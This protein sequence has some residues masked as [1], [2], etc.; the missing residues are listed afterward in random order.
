MNKLDNCCFVYC[1]T[2]RRFVDEAI[3]S[4]LSV[5]AVMPNV[6]RVLFT[7]DDESTRL[8]G[9]G[10]FDRVDV[11][12]DPDYGFRDKIRPLADLEFD[13]IVFLDSD[14]FMM[15]SISEVFELLD[16]FELAFCY[17]PIRY[18]PDYALEGVSDAFTEPNT[19]VLAF[20]RTEAVV[21]LLRKWDK[22]YIEQMGS[23]CPPDHDQ[24]SFREVVYKSDVKF[25]IL[26]CEYNLRT[27]FPYFKGRGILTKILHSRG[28]DLEQALEALDG[29]VE[30]HVDP[31]ELLGVRRR[32]YRILMDISY[33][34]KRVLRNAK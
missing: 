28:R 11:I 12:L 32:F 17:S 24:P 6:P 2:G 34:I 5:K 20:R 15:N 16:V 7:N 29:N 3:Q 9:T 8:A 27:V 23:C 10:V 4:A 18:C 25:C 1:A 13:K 19:G 26:P 21:E 14:T 31:K 22:L 30:F 33:I